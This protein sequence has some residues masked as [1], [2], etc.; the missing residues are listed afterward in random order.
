MPWIP[1]LALPFAGLLARR[2][3]SE[4]RDKRLAAERQELV[5]VGTHH[6]DE[7]GF[8]VHADSRDTLR[9]LE[10]DIREYYQSRA[11]E[12]DRTLQQALV[13]AERQRAAI[14]T[15]ASS[16]GPD[17]S[18]DRETIRDLMTVARRLVTIGAEQ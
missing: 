18:G 1:L 9:R 15:A 5:R 10:Q 6:L 16:D 11:D 3:F 13:A 14:A 17:M 7:V 4:D 12:L 8:I 2:A